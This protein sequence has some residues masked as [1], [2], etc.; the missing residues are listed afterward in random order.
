MGG[1]CFMVDG[2]M[3]VCASQDRLMVRWDPAGYE[4]ALNRPG[5]APMDFTGRPMKRFG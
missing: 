4:A 3:T 1:I 2:K 5:V